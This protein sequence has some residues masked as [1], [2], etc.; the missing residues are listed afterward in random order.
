MSFIPR[1]NKHLIWLDSVIYQGPLSADLKLPSW[2]YPDWGSHILIFRIL[3][4]IIVYFEDFCERVYF[5]RWKSFHQCGATLLSSCWAITAAHCYIDPE[6]TNDV[7]SLEAAKWVPLI[8]WLRLHS[9]WLNWTIGVKIRWAIHFFVVEITFCGT[10][11]FI[12]IYIRCRYVIFVVF[13]NV[14]I[15]MEPSL[16]I[17]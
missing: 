10:V 6:K 8:N 3:K 2:K 11:H 1:L 14:I 4:T 12:C 17:W 16:N 15:W 5:R 9:I 7:V 13:W